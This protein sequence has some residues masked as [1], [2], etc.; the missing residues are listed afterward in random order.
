[1]ID[2][3]RVQVQAHIRPLI[4]RQA[5]ALICGKPDLGIKTAQVIRRRRGGLHRH[6]AVGI[7]NDDLLIMAQFQVASDIGNVR[8]RTAGGLQTIGHE[9][10]ERSGGDISQRLA[11][12]VVR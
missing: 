10:G 7:S 8:L 2:I 6:V 12:P 5:T 11:A 4:A 1:M 9:N 3:V